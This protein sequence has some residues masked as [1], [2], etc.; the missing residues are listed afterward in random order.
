V[1]AQKRTWCVW[2]DTRFLS[3]QS[4]SSC[5]DCS[6]MRTSDGAL[7]SIALRRWGE[8][9]AEG[10]E[11]TPGELDLFIESDARVKLSLDGRIALLIHYVGSLVDS[12]GERPRRVCVSGRPCMERVGGGSDRSAPGFD[13]IDVGTGQGPLTVCADQ[14]RR[15]FIGRRG[16]SQIGRLL[17]SAPGR[18]R[19]ESCSSDRRDLSPPRPP[20]LG[21]SVRR[22]FECPDAQGA[23]S[24][25]GRAASA[26]GCGSAWARLIS[27]CHFQIS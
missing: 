12:A 20:S 11:L 3:P 14:R 19:V 26:A 17:S 9:H 10:I 7:L 22:W 25:N 21:C 13:D 4:K 6:R 27:K 15:Q 16:H 18:P 8:L 24:G 5:I 23:G 1:C 2:A